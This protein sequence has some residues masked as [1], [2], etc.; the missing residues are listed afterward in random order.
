MSGLGSS[1]WGSTAWGLGGSGAPP[2]VS[3][4]YAVG[5]RVLRVTFSAA[6]EARMDAPGTVLDPNAWEVTRLDTNARLYV[7]SVGVYAAPLVYD[8]LLQSPLAS[9]NF[10]HRV[11][12]T[13]LRSTA[14]ALLAVVDDSAVAGTLDRSVSTPERRIVRRR[15][16]VEDLRSVPI[17][18]G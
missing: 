6:P 1:A 15:Q 7:L 14:G 13:G 5:S 17:P 4:I 10:Q 2:V 11:Q 9:N 18:T 16:A 12:A 3:S 8:L